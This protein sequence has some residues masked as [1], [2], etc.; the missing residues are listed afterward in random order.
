MSSFKFLL[1]LPLLFLISSSQ[2]VP[3][4]DL[5]STTD[6]K[7][8]VPDPFHL[9]QFKKY[10]DP[11]VLTLT[12]NTFNEVMLNFPHIVVLFKSSSNK[13]I[14]EGYERLAK[15]IRKNNQVIFG[16]YTPKP[17]NDE[18][19]PKFKVHDFPGIFF[20]D[21]TKKYPFSGNMSNLT[22]VK[23]FIM[24]FLFREIIEI[25]TQSDFLAFHNRPNKTKLLAVYGH[26]MKKER[27][28]LEEM[29]KNDLFADSGPFIIGLTEDQSIVPYPENVELPSLILYNHFTEEEEANIVKYDGDFND[30]QEILAFTQ[31]NSLPLVSVFKEE[32]SFRIFAGAVDV[33]ML[34]LLNKNRDNSKE[35]EEFKKAAKFNK[36]E[37]LHF[38]R[39]IFCIVYFEEENKDFLDF[40][41]I[42]KEEDLKEPKIFITKIDNQ[43]QKMDKFLFEKDEI[44]QEYIKD[45][46]EEFRKK[47]LR[48]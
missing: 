4:P 16:V 22:E 9:P 2:M 15:N 7:N 42:E 8:M 26:N 34:M 12:P 23:T 18:F 44:I 30:G 48:R 20:V 39:I 25:K 32:N 37:E 47:Q 41:G 33:Q 24:D 10:V 6:P 19:L 38:E 3:V 36:E 27:K 5:E 45:F 35:I 1:L 11:L 29:L 14:E 40:F 17:E 21:K 28:L 31:L 43:I 46:T 13:E